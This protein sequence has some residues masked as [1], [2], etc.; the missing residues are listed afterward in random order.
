MVCKPFLSLVKLGYRCTHTLFFFKYDNCLVVV[1]M[2][3][4][5]QP[6]SVWVNCHCLI[7]SMYQWLVG[8]NWA[9][10]ERYID[11]KKTL[12]KYGGF[13]MCVCL[14]SQIDRDRRVFPETERTSY[15][16]LKTDIVRMG[17]MWH[18]KTKKNAEIDSQRRKQG[19]H[20]REIIGRCC[21]WKLFSPLFC[22]LCTVC[23]TRVKIFNNLFLLFIWS[24][25]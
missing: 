13:C 20:V 19:G 17:G 7:K 5:C 16:N 8:L 18:T 12:V 21:T 10:T 11:T 2:E 23:S 6:W 25:F 14:F 4:I 1:I 3:R 24:L 9:W 22:K 15:P